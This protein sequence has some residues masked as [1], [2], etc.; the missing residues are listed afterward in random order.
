VSRTDDLNAI[1]DYM[2]AT[3]ART[4]KAIQL[5]DSWLK[6]FDQLSWYTKNVS[7]GDDYDEA[8]NRRNAFN[9]ANALTSEELE[10]AKRT[11]REGFTTEEMEGERK[12]VLSSGRFPEDP[13]IIPFWGKVLITLGAIGGTAYLGKTAIKEAFKRR[14]MG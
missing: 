2:S 13:T 4:P 9:E 14:I 6:W 11:A 8:R 1:A 10:M 3:A 5:K 12:R 7:P